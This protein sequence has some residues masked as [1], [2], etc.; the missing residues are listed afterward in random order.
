VDA[1]RRVRRIAVL[2]Y[3]RSAASDLLRALLRARGFGVLP[4]PR[5]LRALGSDALPLSA[6]SL[7]RLDGH[8]FYICGRLNR[9][10]VDDRGFGDGLSGH[11]RFRE[12]GLCNAVNL[13]VLSARINRYRHRAAHQVWASKDPDRAL[14]V[15]IDAQ[16]A[17]LARGAKQIDHGREAVL[18]LVE[19][20]D[21]GT[22]NAFACRTYIGQRGGVAASENARWIALMPSC[23]VNGDGGSCS[24]SSSAGVTGPPCIV[25]QGG[26][27]MLPHRLRLV[28]RRF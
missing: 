10:G 5:R 15:T 1:A 20:F 7:R 4:G 8:H 17:F 19:S 13:D 21:R 9:L 16:N 11:R 14:T 12:N 3:E 24:S 25:G 2:I 22:E 28:A 6:A 18:A 26:D 23:I 27:A